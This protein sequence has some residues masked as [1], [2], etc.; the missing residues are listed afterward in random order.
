MCLHYFTLEDT[1]WNLCICNTYLLCVAF[2]KCFIDFFCDLIFTYGIKFCMFKFRKD[3]YLQVFFFA[4]L[5]SMVNIHCIIK[6]HP[7]QGCNILVV[8]YRRA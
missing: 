4:I 1:K 7:L 3:F 6:F 2:I 5:A 8:A